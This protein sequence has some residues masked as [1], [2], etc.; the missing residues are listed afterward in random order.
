MNSNG[1]ANEL[2]RP[3]STKGTKPSSPIVP[4]T[5]AQKKKKMSVYPGAQN[6]PSALGI[7]S[8]AAAAIFDVSESNQISEPTWKLRIIPSD[9]TSLTVIK[10]SWEMVQPGRAAKARETRESFLRLFESG[11][12]RTT[13]FYVPPAAETLSHLQRKGKAEQ[14]VLQGSDIAYKHWTIVKKNANATTSGGLSL[15]SMAAGSEPLAELTVYGPDGEVL[16][17][18]IET[19]SKVSVTNQVPS[20]ISNVDTSKERYSTTNIEHPKDRLSSTTIEYSKDRTSGPRK[21]KLTNLT[22]VAEDKDKTRI[23]NSTTETSNHNRHLSF[24]PNVTEFGSSTS[25]DAFAFADTQM[26]DESNTDI[27]D[28]LQSSWPPQYLGRVL[29]EQERQARALTRQVEFSNQ[30]A[31]TMTLK[32]DRVKN[33]EER[34]RDM[35]AQQEKLDMYMKLVEQERVEDLNSRERYR[36]RVIKEI[37]EANIRRIAQENQK[38]AELAAIELGTDESTASNA[39]DKGKKRSKK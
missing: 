26:E 21:S 4:P 5:S 25:E 2:G 36:Q 7:S 29:N 9:L 20:M 33:R 28:N 24:N 12:M 3:S 1:G 39:T 13:A 19:Q 38:A 16:P 22:S 27:E 10:D 31:A 34:A 8:I 17:V 15:M 32:V 23:N 14:R 18:E 11:A 37:E 30:L 35:L 6:S